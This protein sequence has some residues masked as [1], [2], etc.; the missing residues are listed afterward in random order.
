MRAAWCETHEEVG[1]VSH[2]LVYSEHVQEAMSEGKRGHYEDGL[3][4]KTGRCDDLWEE[5][6]NVADI[7]M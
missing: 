6:G 5:Q 4:V 1:L 7:R 2:C 3:A